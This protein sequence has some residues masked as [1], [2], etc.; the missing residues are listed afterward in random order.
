MSASKWR[1]GITSANQE[2]NTVLFLS[3]EGAQGLVE[4]ALILVL[5]AIVVLVILALLGPDLGNFVN[6]IINSAREIFS[7]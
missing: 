6:N 7:R 4:Y 5:I 2:V 1:R 3:R